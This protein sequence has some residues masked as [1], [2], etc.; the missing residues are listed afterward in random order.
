MSK[1]DQVTFKG[2]STHHM[3]DWSCCTVAKENSFYHTEMWITMRQGLLSFLDVPKNMVKWKIW[4]LFFYHSS[5]VIYQTGPK[6]VFMKNKKKKMKKKK[7]K[8]KTKY[9]QSKALVE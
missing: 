8:D 7:N 4:L 2:E 1:V 9:V 5:L 3:Q 6:E